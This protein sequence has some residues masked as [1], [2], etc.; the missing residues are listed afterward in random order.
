MPH[1]V[2]SNGPPVE[3]AMTYQAWSITL[4]APR[5]SKSGL[6]VVQILLRPPLDTSSYQ[7][8]VEGVEFETAEKALAFGGKRAQQYIDGKDVLGP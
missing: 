3:A 2:T 7:I 6:F 4:I 1:M 5:D 8:D